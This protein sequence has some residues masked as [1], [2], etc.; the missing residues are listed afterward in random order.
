[1]NEFKL[2]VAGGRDF[3]DYALVERVLFAMADTE[4]ADYGVSIVSGMARGAD[5]LGHRFAKANGVQ[6]YEF[7]ADWD[8]LGK[9]AGHRRNEDMGRFADGL[10]AFFDGSSKGTAGMI[11]FMQKLGKP[12][13]IINY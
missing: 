12:V 7:Y 1:M 13:T 3:N 5:A 9:S 10:L 11:A 4:L 6:V 8:G 2:I